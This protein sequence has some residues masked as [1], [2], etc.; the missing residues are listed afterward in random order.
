M[1]SPRLKC[2]S[3][4]LNLTCCCRVVLLDLWWN[5]QIEQQVGPQAVGYPVLAQELPDPNESKCRLLIALI[6]S[7]RL[8]MSRSTKS[9]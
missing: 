8:R 6:D 9:R 3:V 2:G 1:H 4:G 5:P 7:D